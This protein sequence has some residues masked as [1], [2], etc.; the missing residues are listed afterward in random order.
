MSH[1]LIINTGYFL[2]LLFSMYVY[3]RL[4]KTKSE[5]CD[6]HQVAVSFGTGLFGFMFLSHFLISSNNY[7]DINTMLVGV[8][9][10]SIING[11]I[12]CFLAN[13]KLNKMGV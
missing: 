11:F 12:S 1:L 7:S 3:R 2:L 4:H 10:T 9:W 6:S 5:S 13:K 8:L